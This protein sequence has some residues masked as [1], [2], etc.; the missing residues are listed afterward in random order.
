MSAERLCSVLSDHLL[1]PRTDKV[2][3]LIL[4]LQDRVAVLKVLLMSKE[5]SGHFMQIYGP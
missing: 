5:C 1:S 3:F 2:S 4:V